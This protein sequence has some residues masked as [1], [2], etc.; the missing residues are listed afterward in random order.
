[1]TVRLAGQIPVGATCA[2]TFDDGQGP[3]QSTLDCAEPINLRVAYGRATVATVDVSSGADA[4][5]R[6]TTE[7]RVRDIFIAGLGNS[8]ASGEG[9]PDRQIALVR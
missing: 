3:R 2:W 4:P 8:I 6:V 7:I 9:N 5:Q 1:M